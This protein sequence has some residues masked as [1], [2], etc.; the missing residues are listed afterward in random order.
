MKIW[1]GTS[2]LIGFTML[3]A[4]TDI[5]DRKVLNKHLLTMLLA[6]LVFKTISPNVFQFSLLGLALPFLVHYI[7]F[8]LSLVSAGDVKLFMVIGL[9]TGPEFVVTCMAISYAVGGLVALCLMVRSKSLLNRLKSIYF[10][11]WNMIIGQKLQAYTSSHGKALAMPFALM[12]HLAVLVQVFCLGG[13]N[14]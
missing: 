8:K 10:Y 5:K 13:L 11:T 2:I 7:P 1:I 9:F 12:I 14:G 6:G 4:F 3:T